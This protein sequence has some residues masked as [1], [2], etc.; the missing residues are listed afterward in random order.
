MSGCSC[1]GQ[2]CS[3]R[4]D[5]YIPYVLFSSQCSHDCVKCVVLTYFIVRLL[6]NNVVDILIHESQSACDR[7]IE[8]VVQ[9][10]TMTVVGYPIRSNQYSY[11]EVFDL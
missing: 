10:H 9:S 11:H 4:T 3:S 8:M 5:I 7:V 6:Y 2:H 1:V